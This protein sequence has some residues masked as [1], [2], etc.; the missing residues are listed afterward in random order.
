[1]L[2]GCLLATL[3]GCASNDVLVQRVTELENQNQTLVKQVQELTETVN[4]DRKK[5]DFM[6]FE[7]GLLRKEVLDKERAELDDSQKEQI[8]K[9]V[10][11]LESEKAN[12]QDIS[13]KLFAF[14]KGAVVV[15][16]EAMRTPNIQHRS[17]FEAALG[18]MPVQDVTQVLSIA[19]KD[20]V[21]KF[22]AAR[23]LGNIQDNLSVQILARALL[24]ADES[25][26]FAIA[27]SLVKLK[28]KRSIPVLIESL[29]SIDQSIRALAINLLSKITN[30]QTFDYK[31][32]NSAKEQ[33]WAIKKWEDWWL[34]EA[35]NFT[36][37]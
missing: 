36:F 8:N 6:H 4:I 12:I 28:D 24:D 34:K 30:G 15:L 29:K 18:L 14:G 3:L 35:A 20:S 2:A 11:M 32:Y 37:P 33:Q 1:M 13:S 22:S 16:T 31:H 7:L 5:V 19:L 21:L 23:V 27:E 9:L 26:S 17:R 25:F 10:K